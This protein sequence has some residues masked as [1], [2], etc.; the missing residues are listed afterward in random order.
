MCCLQILPIRCAQATWRDLKT[1]Q[2][3]INDEVVNLYMLLIQQR[4]G[5]Y[6]FSRCEVYPGSEPSGT[7]W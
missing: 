3:W 7:A 2:G 1:L 4:S 5:M 6:S